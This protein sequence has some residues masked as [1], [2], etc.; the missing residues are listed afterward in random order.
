MVR[1]QPGGL[2]F[3]EEVLEGRS[4]AQRVV[5]VGE[6]PR[7]VEQLQPATRHALVGGLSVLHRDD[8]VALTP[9]D[10]RRHLRGQIEAVGGVDPLAGRVDHRR[11][12]CG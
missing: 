4:E 2:G 11:A 9:H 6:V 1:V 12:G 7:L 3:R 5:E 8:P 10:Q